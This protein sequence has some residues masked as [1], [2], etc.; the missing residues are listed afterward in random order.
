M[1]R[2]IEAANAYVKM[3]CPF[4]DHKYFPAYHAAPPV[5]WVNDPCG[6]IEAFGQYHLYGQYHPYSSQWGP[7]HWGHWASDDLVKWDW[8]GVA[9]A[10]D[11]SADEG[12]CFTGTAQMDGEEMLVA[13]AGLEADGEGGHYQQQCMAV[14]RDGAHFIKAERNPVIGRA[15]LPEGG[16]SVDFRD[17]CL[18]RWGDEWRLL[19][20]NRNGQGGSL[21]QY[22]SCDGL[23]WEMK[24]IFLD[25][26]DQMLECP[27]L[28]VRDGRA[29]LLLSVMD[30]PMEKISAYESV[31]RALGDSG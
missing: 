7:M 9:L 26:F 19:A 15:M 4:V 20:T 6:F 8:Q 11:T 18:F 24:G 23:H 1:K 28:V 27:D 30:M 25:G 22:A 14:S 21:V 10:P 16:S 17:P 13:Y 12:G 2:T 5:G 31:Y 3:E 29:L